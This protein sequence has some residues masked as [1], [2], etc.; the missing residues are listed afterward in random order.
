MQTN[1]SGGGKFHGGNRNVSS[2]VVRSK[3]RR[4]CVA[5]AEVSC[6]HTAEG[7]AARDGGVLVLPV[8]RLSSGQA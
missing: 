4:Q 5:E 8:C 7:S 3:W 1:K 2:N 6:V